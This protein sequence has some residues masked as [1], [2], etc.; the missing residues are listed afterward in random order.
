MRTF[1][2]QPDVYAVSATHSPCQR[3]RY[4]LTRQWNRDGGRVA[5]IGLNPSTATAHL[6]DP[7]VRRCVNF[8]RAW[9]FGSM[10]MLNAFAWRSTDPRGLRL[11]DDPVGPEN[12]ARVLEACKACLL[13]VACW[14]KHAAY[15]SR[16]ADLRKLLTGFPLYA[17]GFN[18]DGSPKHPLY[19]SSHIKDLQLVA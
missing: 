19:L 11:T 1:P 18:G 16:A 2:T 13:L 8:A 4:T 5:F 3:Y 6:D 10:V 15:Q 7:T 12:D 17:F 14:G 9:G